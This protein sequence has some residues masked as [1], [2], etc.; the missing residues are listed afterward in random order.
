MLKRFSTAKKP[1][2]SQNGGIRGAEIP[3]PITTKFCMSGAVHDLMTH[4]NFGENRLRGV[5]MARG[6]ILAFSINL[7]RRHYNTLSHYRASV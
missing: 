6:Q 4:V 3:E 5:G 2:S 7:L 1:K